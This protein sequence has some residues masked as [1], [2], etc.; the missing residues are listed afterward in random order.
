MLAESAMK[1][2]PSGPVDRRDADRL[3][4]FAGGLPIKPSGRFSD[5]GDQAVRLAP[6]LP[7]VEPEH[8][9]DLTPLARERQANRLVQLLH[10]PCRV[11]VAEE[12]GGDAVL[13]RRGAPDDLGQVGGEL[14]VLG[15]PGGDIETELGTVGLAT[16]A[17]NFGNSL[18]IG[19]LLARMGAQL[20]LSP[21]AWA[22]DADHDHEREPYDKL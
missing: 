2:G 20:I 8:R 1:G 18:A 17:D 10:A 19:H 16:C 22:V 3:D 5:Q 12:D 11:A 21:S 6:A 13:V 7:G 14:L 4:A 9:T 15:R